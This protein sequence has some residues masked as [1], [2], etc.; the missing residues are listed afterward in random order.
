MRRW[1][2]RGAGVPNAQVRVPAP[3]RGR[4]HPGGA[5]LRPRACGSPEGKRG[6]P[7]TGSPGRGRSVPGCGLLLYFQGVGESSFLPFSRDA[8]LSPEL[9]APSPIPSRR[10]GVLFALNPPETNAQFPNPGVFRELV[11]EP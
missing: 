5:R 9:P 8:L 6:N 2:G 7:G 3:C 4:R 11:W 10:A 1:E